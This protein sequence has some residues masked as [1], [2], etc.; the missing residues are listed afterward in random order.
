M[1]MNILVLIP[2]NERHKKILEGKAP[3]SQFVY[4]STQGV[5][6]EQVR[7][8]GIIL[9]NPPSSMLA[10]LEGLEWIQLQSAGA[11]SYV[12]PGVMPRR[13]ALTNA[14]GAY[15]LAVSEHMLGTLLEIYKKLNLYWDNQNN[16]KWA[17]EGTVKSIYDSSALI[18]GLGDIGSEF[19]KRIKALGGRTVG[20]RRTA[21]GKPDYLDELC[22]PDRLDA[23][24]PDADIVALSLPDTK[25][26]RGLIDRRRL[27]LMKK[28]AVIINVGRGNAIDTE[29]LCDALE[30]GRLLGACL[31]VTDPEPLPAE[32]RLW[33][34]KNA[35]ITPHISGWTHLPET[36]ERIVAISARNLEAFMNSKPLENTVDF[37]TGYRSVQ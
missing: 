4:S 14:T 3:S 37:S 23:L 28:D 5:T 7:R 29:A 17:D 34:L 2:V 26:T 20:I 25:E 22:L 18:V 8:A 9:G 12:L 27:G 35:V 36:L 6:P 31:D 13:V 30:A 32:H 1:K 24:L 21:C 10:G 11:E 19:A 33:K 16:A 15:G